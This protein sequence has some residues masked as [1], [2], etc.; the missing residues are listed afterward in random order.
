[1]NVQFE[2]ATGGNGAL[3]YSAA[4]VPLGLSF[5]ANTRRLLSGQFPADQAGADWEVVCVATDADGDEAEQSVAF[6]VRLAQGG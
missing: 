1:M 6:A 4:P 3:T 5:D 2:V